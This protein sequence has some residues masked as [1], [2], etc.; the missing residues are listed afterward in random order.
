MHNISDFLTLF[1]RINNGQE[2]KLKGTP[3]EFANNMSKYY[4]RI[5][6]KL[7]GVGQKLEA[8]IDG[9]VHV[10]TV[11]DFT[12][13]QMLVHL[14]GHNDARDFWATPQSPR[15]RAINWHK[16]SSIQMIPPP[17]GGRSQ[18]SWE[19]YLDETGTQAVLPE[20]LNPTDRYC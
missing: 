14:D 7:L 16:K 2:G 15:V 19:S 12:G 1:R 11:V 10:G 13:S 8:F 6:K 3:R 20:V 18:F 5:D 4:D 17:P 9:K